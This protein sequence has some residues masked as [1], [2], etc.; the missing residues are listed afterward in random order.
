M[1]V[2][3]KDYKERLLEHINRPLFMRLRE[4]YLSDMVSILEAAN[5]GKCSSSEAFDIAS[6]LQAK[7]KILRDGGPLEK[8]L[9]KADILILDKV[10]NDVNGPKTEKINVL[11]LTDKDNNTELN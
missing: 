9:R 7:F 4:S 2:S 6:D 3:D 10:L 1:D 11:D 8:L 5:E